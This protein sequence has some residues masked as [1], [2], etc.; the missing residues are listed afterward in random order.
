MGKSSYTHFLVTRSEILDVLVQCK[1][2][3]IHLHQHSNDYTLVLYGKTGSSLSNLS[4]SVNSPS[5]INELSK[6]RLLRAI[7]SRYLSVQTCCS[8]ATVFFSVSI[9]PEKGRKK[10]FPGVCRVRKHPLLLERVSSG[11]LEKRWS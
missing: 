5:Y 2:S 7:I 1:R 8:Y 9:V 3:Q 4:K 11:S 10:R 6:A